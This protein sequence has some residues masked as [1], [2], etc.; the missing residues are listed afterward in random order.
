MRPSVP[1]S[2]ISAVLFGVFLKNPREFAEVLQMR[3]PSQKTLWLHAVRRCV[4]QQQQ[5]NKTVLIICLS[6]W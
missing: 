2:P 1:T 6:T 3:T 5:L 4:Q